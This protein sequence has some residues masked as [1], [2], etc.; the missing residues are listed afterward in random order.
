MRIKY[1]RLIGNLKTCLMHCLS[2][3]HLTE[4]KHEVCPTAKVEEE[5]SDRAEPEVTSATL[6]RSTFLID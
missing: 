5:E 6:S 3:C 4:D 1:A 2:L